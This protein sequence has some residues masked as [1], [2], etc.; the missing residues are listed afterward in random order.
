[1]K[2]ERRRFLTIM[3]AL[4]LL[5]VGGVAYSDDDDETVIRWDIVNLPPFCPG[6]GGMASATTHHNNNATITLTGSGTFKP[7]D[8]EDVT[9]GG[10]WTTAAGSGTY[11]VI[12]LVSWHRA[13]GTLDCP[14]DTIRGER[15]AGLAV[16]RIRYQ[17]G[18]K[19]VLT[20]SCR[21]AGTPPGVFEGIAVSK[22]FI[23]YTHNVEPAPGVNANRTLFHIQEEDEEEDDEDD[24]DDD[25]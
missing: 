25:G 6:P 24:E 4:V 12:E 11:T 7:D 1:M 2:A 8:R 5:F 14:N 18:S 22:G 15:A 20:I 23:D 3:A 19:G 9:G 13:P 17:D 10:T 21:L 16:L